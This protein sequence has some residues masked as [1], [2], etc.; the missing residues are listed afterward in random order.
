MS[1]KYAIASYADARAHRPNL[2]R[3]PYPLF[4][5][6]RVLDDIAGSIGVLPPETGGVLL[7]P[8]YDL[9]FDTFIYDEVGSASRSVAVYRPDDRGL[10]QKIHQLLDQPAERIRF[11]AG[12]VHSHPNGMGTPSGEAGVGLGDLGYVKECFRQ[13]ED[14]AAFAMPILTNTG[15]KKLPL[16]WPWIVLRDD[17]A[18]P[19]YADVVVVAEGEYP[20]YPFNRPTAAPVSTRHES[21]VV[22]L[23]FEEVA[24][25]SRSTFALDDT[26]LRFTQGD[27]VVELDLPSPWDA[28]QPPRLRIVMEATAE[29]ITLSVPWRTR[30]TR[31]IEERLAE[32]IRRAFVFTHVL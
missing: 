30:G 17:P 3:S 28:R 18:K 24:E 6:D 26:R 12:F 15:A 11:L 13:F 16:I 32:A 27:A 1:D 2:R 4:M 20:T 21:P 10:T 9:A 31:R 7:R 19:L 23:D 14:M 29:P 22:F 8:V 25:R 5:T